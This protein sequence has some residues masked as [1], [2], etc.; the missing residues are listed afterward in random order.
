MGLLNRYKSTMHGNYKIAVFKYGLLIGIGLSLVILFRY[1]FK[2]PISEPVSYYEDISMLVFLFI[3]V[4]LY[5]RGL[6]ERKITLKES[7]IL[8][9]GSGII[10]SIIYGIFLFVYSQY[11]DI[12]IQQRCFEIQRAVKTNINL[13]DEELMLMVKPSSIAFSAILLSSVLTILWALIIAILLRN[14]QGILIGKEMKN[15]EKDK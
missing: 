1:W 8:G 2:M 6:K 4:F 5:K 7:Y 13:N 12:D 15:L 3:A 10:A 9:L 14:E 11:I